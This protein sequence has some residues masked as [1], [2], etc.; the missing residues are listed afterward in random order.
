MES[1]HNTVLKS[2]RS[3]MLSTGAKVIRIG[4]KPGVEGLNGSWVCRRGVTLAP[5]AADLR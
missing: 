3:A 5:Y 4:V 2:R 1:E